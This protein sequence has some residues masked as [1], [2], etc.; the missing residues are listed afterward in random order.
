MQI[1]FTSRV[2]QEKQNLWHRHCTRVQ[3]WAL[4]DPNPVLPT[5]LS[6]AEGIKGQADDGDDTERYIQF[7]ASQVLWLEVENLDMAVSGS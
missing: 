4:K 5:R 1:I 7:H 2:P 3:G 6:S